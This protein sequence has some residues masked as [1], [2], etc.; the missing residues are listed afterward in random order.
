MTTSAH[1]FPFRS[2]PLSV[3]LASL[4]L[5][6]PLRFPFASSFFPF[7]LLPFRSARFRFRILSFLFFLSALRRFRLPVAFPAP[8]ARLS[9]PS[10]LPL[11]YRLVSHPVSPVPLIQHSCLFPFAPPCFAPTAVPQVLPVPSAFCRFL[12]RIRPCVRFRRFH[13]ASF[14]PLSFR[15]V[16]VRL[17]SSLLGLCFFLSPLHPSASQWLPDCPLRFPSPLGSASRFGFPPS[18]SP[19]VCFRFPWFFSQPP[20]PFGILRLGRLRL[21]YSVPLLFLSPLTH[22]PHSGSCVCLP[23]LSGSGLPLSFLHPFVSSG[24]SF[25]RSLPLRL[26]RFRSLRPP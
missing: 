20:A 26:L 19:P 18:F 25:L 6:F 4:L 22:L 5:G 23:S 14:P 10:D 13:P 11:P 3:P 15:F 1:P 12:S 17:G 21:R 9:A 2:L 8:Q 16:V 24:T 7:R